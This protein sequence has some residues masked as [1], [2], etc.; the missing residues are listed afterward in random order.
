MLGLP[1]IFNL[2]KVI[3]AAMQYTLLDRGNQSKLER[4]GKY[5]LARPCAQAVWK[6]SLDDKVDRR[7]LFQFSWGV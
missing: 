5:V 3:P 2:K 7:S 1:S 4:F 6:P